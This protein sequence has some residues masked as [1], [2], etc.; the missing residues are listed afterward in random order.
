MNLAESFLNPE[1]LMWLLLIPLLVVAYI[2]IVRRKKKTGM[3]YTNTAV[4]GAVVPKQSQW[5][6]HLAVAMTLAS[7]A[8]IIM[9]WARPNGVE[10]VPRERATIV[11]V[12]DV[13]QSMRATDV[14]PNRMDA[15][16]ELSKAFLNTLPAKYNV[17]VVSLSGNPAIKL[18]PTTDRSLAVR[19]ID[20]LTTQDSTA[21]GPALQTALS[22]IRMAPKG[23]DGSTAPG[24]VVMLSDGDNTAAS[25]PLQAAAELAQAKV[26]LYTIGYGTQN[27]SVDLDGVR[28]PVPPNLDLMRELASSTGGSFSS[29]ESAGQLQNVYANLASEVGFEEVKKETTALWAGY[30]LAF[31]VVAA[32]AAVSLGARWP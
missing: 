14:K 10:R 28:E 16:K 22:A 12:L 17:A 19:S 5:R 32:L 4:L 20:A 15:A 6:R 9:A 25:S 1:R 29:A 27:G 21:I 26:P 30:A 23:D 2:I 7:L 11:L 18:P 3:R 8:A 24:A 13:S 31:G